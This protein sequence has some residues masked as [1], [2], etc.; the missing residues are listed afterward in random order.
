MRSNIN[1]VLKLVDGGVQVCGPLKWDDGESKAIAVVTISQ[2]DRI[3][4][5]SSSPPNFDVSD[6]EWSFTVPPALP[7]KKF[8][9]GPAHVTAQIFALGEGIATFVYPCD[10]EVELEE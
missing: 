3:A 8:K 10:K 2:N 9:K 7:H 4:G 5:V 6:T 1:D